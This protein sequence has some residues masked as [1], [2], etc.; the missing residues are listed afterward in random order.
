M[1]RGSRWTVGLLVDSN[2]FWIGIARVRTDG[3]GVKAG[4][5]AASGLY[6]GGVG[7]VTGGV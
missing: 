4:V 5:K 2:G 6:S 3:G 1:V 7:V